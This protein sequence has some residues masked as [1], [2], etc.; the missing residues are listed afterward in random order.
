MEAQEYALAEA[1]KP[2]LGSLGYLLVSLGALFSIS[3]ALN[4]TLYGGA[5]I[6]YALAKEGE[7]PEL[8]ERKVWFRAPEGLYLTA[9]LGLAFAVS[10]NLNGIASI[11]SAVFMVVYLFVLLSHFRLTGEVGGR[12]SIIGVGLGTI[13]VV[14]LLLM[15][16]QWGTDRGAF[17]ATWGTLA[18]SLIVEAI[19]R[20]LTKRGIVTRS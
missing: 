13:G 2:F 10:F 4:A 1:A 18:G 8:F 16:Y 5:N 20:R 19:Y 6:A 12:R 17:Y 3:S 15:R 11:A 9:I 7:L 14:F